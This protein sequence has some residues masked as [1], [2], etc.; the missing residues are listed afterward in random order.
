[1][2]LFPPD[3]PGVDPGFDDREFWAHCRNRELRFQTCADCGTPRHP[4]GPVCPSCRSLAVEWVEAP[5][6]AELY[7]FTVVHY[8]SHPAVKP[9]LPYVVGLVTFAGL[10]GVKLVSN[11]TGCDPAD[12]RI[13]MKLQFWWDD[14]GDGQFLP[15]FRPV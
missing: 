5:V 3:M 12:V 8:A 10:P 9:N 4:P 6:E 2:A 14:I 15:R 11:I 1:M 13:G 7:S